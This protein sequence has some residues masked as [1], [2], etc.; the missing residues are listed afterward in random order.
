[1]DKTNLLLP[2]GI[3]TPK[4]IYFFE[5]YQFSVRFAVFSKRKFFRGL[6]G[7]HGFQTYHKVL[8]YMVLSFFEPKKTIFYENIWGNKKAPHLTYIFDP[9]TMGLSANPFPQRVLIYQLYFTQNHCEKIFCKAK[10]NLEKSRIFGS[11]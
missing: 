8:K 2:Q 5:Y 9:A 10:L 3:L 7:S 11:F 1:M 4:K 6:R